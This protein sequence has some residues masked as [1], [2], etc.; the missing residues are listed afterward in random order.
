MLA[1][2]K[3]I[4][5][6]LVCLTVCLSNVLWKYRRTRLRSNDLVY[7]SVPLQ[8]SMT[9]L[10][11]NGLVLCLC[12][13]HNTSKEAFLV[14][15]NRVFNEPLGHSLRSFACTIHSLT[16]SAMLHFAPLA[17][18]A[19]LAHCVHGLAHS[20]CSLTRGT[21]KFM[22]MCSC[23]KRVKWEQTRFSSLLETSPM[24]STFI[25]ELPLSYEGVSKVCERSHNWERSAVGVAKRSA[26]ELVSRASERSEWCER[27][28]AAHA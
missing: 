7:I 10:L 28:N 23:C 12:H 5:T 18:L 3:V 24:C 27:L 26:A 20:F 22:N 11:C 14:R 6:V 4:L 15:D 25:Y 9:I 8:P 2:S 13:S 17:T 1:Y 16:R 21:V 19:S